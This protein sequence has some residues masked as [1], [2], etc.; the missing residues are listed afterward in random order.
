VRLKQKGLGYIDQIGPGLTGVGKLFSL[1]SLPLLVTGIMAY[2][3]P[4]KRL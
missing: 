4:S 2:T 1:F 3:L